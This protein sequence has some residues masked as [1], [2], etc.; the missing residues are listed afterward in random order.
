MHPL[1]GLRPP[2]QP[3]SDAALM[4][5]VRKGEIDSFRHLYRRHDAAVQ[6]YDVQ[7]VAGPLHAQEV[8]SRVFADLLHQVLAG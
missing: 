5:A 1:L 2:Q 3:L 6:A 8:T 4:L 7:R